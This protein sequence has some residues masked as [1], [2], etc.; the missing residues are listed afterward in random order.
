MENHNDNDSPV[1]QNNE[2][3]SGI[4]DS[5]AK[6]DAY[7]R[8]T[9]SGDGGRRTPAMEGI[10]Q[11]VTPNNSEG[12]RGKTSQAHD[13]RKACHNCG[14]LDHL[15]RNCPRPQNN[16]FVFR[17][18]AINESFHDMDDRTK[19]AED[20]AKEKLKEIDDL[21][22]ELSE[23]RKKKVVEQKNVPEFDVEGFN[24]EWA[25]KDENQ[26]Y[27]RYNEIS[28]HHPWHKFP[29]D[30]EGD[31]RMVNTYVIVQKPK[32]ASILATLSALISMKC[33]YHSLVNLGGSLFTT[34]AHNAAKYGMTHTLYG[35]LPSSHVADGLLK[36]IPTHRSPL[37]SFVLGI[38]HA[39]V[40]F[41]T[42]AV[43][44]KC[45]KLSD[46]LTTSNVLKTLK[47][48]KVEFEY[49]L[50]HE[51]LD[52]RADS[53]SAG[54]LTHEHPQ[55]YY[56]K[57]STIQM[58]S[59][60]GI[61][62]IARRTKRKNTVSLETIVQLTAPNNIVLSSTDQ[63]AWERIQ[64]TNTHL[65]SVNLNRYHTLDDSAID[66]DSQ[67]VAYGRRREIF[68]QRSCDDFHRGTRD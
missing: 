40:M 1:P 26:K 47:Y 67:L 27:I 57:F 39:I 53:I 16:R 52:N 18:N 5:V 65:H 64:Y 61:L 7:T 58:T 20:V 44:W 14:S 36:N 68:Q 48:Y 59:F 22:K 17:A 38:K 46:L 62:A 56:A 50:E 37:A 45:V 6:I 63:V 31:H 13:K 15:V 9:E 42:M 4:S 23:E 8:P 19:A 30:T 35:S 60:F 34:L 66:V 2:V 55:N 28:R 32:W 54:D 10:S 51:E 49:P 41:V 24:I 21:K 43:A 25:E 29:Q 3:N 11:S 33:A 12:N